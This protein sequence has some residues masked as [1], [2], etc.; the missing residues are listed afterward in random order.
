MSNYHHINFFIYYLLFIKIIILI[1][2][3]IKII[4][5]IFYLFKKKIIVK[6]GIAQFYYKK[7]ATLFNDKNKSKY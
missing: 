7:I 1:I 2:K 5:I 3:I 6:N 4:K